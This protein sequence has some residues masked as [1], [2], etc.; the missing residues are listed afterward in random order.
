MLSGFLF[1]QKRSKTFKN[2]YYSWCIHGAYAFC[3]PFYRDFGAFLVRDLCRVSTD[4]FAIIFLLLSQQKQ[5]TA[6]SY[7]EAV[8]WEKIFYEVLFKSCINPAYVSGFAS[9]SASINSSSTRQAWPESA[10]FMVSKNSLIPQ[11]T[12]N[13]FPLCFWKHLCH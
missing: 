2:V 3:N 8:L 7:C 4:F 9:F 11:H 12:R 1:V 10:L 6:A 13:I 5:R